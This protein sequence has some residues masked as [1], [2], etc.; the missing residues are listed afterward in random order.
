M[1]RLIKIFF[2]LTPLFFASCLDVVEE[3]DLNATKGG[4][5]S[6]TF[7]LSQS[8]MKLNTVLK[9]DSIGGYKVPKLTDIE[10]ELSKAVRELRTKP[11][12]S[13]ASYS[14][15]IVEYIFTLKIEFNSLPA[16]NSALM[17][18]SYWKTSEWKPKKDFYQLENNQLIKNIEL[19]EL[20]DGQKGELEKRKESLT[21]ATY[22]F[23]VRNANELALPATSELKLSGNKKAVLFRENF[24]LLSKRQ[25]G[26]TLKAQL[27]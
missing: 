26:V 7:N 11:G 2:L 20:S 13:G 14:L 5:A 27:L 16:L 18:M 19:P 24:Y 6:Y 9:L 12:I 17:G 23:I 1:Y 3:I 8:K 10:R 21:L 25:K 15:N 22:T 4:T